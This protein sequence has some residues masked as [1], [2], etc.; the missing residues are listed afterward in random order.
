MADVVTLSS[1]LRTPTPRRWPAWLVGLAQSL[2]VLVVPTS[3]PRVVLA[4]R[5]GVPLLVIATLSLI[6]ALVVGP[7][8]DVRA[9]VPTEEMIG[10]QSVPISELDLA[11]KLDKAHKLARLMLALDAAIMTP[12]RILLLGAG[13]AMF[14]RFVGGRPAP[15]ALLSLAAHASLPIVVGAVITAV[16]VL[17][18]PRVVPEALAGIVPPG[19]LAAHLGATLGRF[20]GQASVFTAWTILLVVLGF[21]AAAGLRR[22]PGTA[23]ILVGV[24]LYLTVSNIILGPR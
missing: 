1:E 15:R 5:A 24:A 9:Q 10:D 23:A 22:A 16:A 4:R 14:A 6:C 2:G 7:H 13:L 19:P 3:M 17:T 11:T 18:G 21:P 12:L 20:V 8:L